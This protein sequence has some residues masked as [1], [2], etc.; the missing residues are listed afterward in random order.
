MRGIQDTSTADFRSIIGSGT[1]F[2][3]PKFQRDYSW[4]KEQWDDLWQDIEAM[5]EAKDDHYMGYL[6]LQTTEGKDYQI[7][8]GQQRFTTITLLILAAIKCIIKKGGKSEEERTRAKSL[9]DAYV[10][11][12]DPIS[13]EYDNKLVLNRNN[14]DYY[15]DYIVKFDKLRVSDLKATD[16]LMRG[17]F[18]FYEKN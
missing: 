17:C 7:I 5:I 15:K 9:L 12:M 3:V 8:D 11:S 18:E 1:K 14:N 4:E 16:K 2:R 6:V 10:G 13:L